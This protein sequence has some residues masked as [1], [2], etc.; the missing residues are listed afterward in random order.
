[1]SS[2]L[3]LLRDNVLREEFFQTLQER[4]LTQCEKSSHSLPERVRI[5][6]KKKFSLIAEKFSLLLRSCFHIL[7]HYE[8]A[9]NRYKTEF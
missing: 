8:T 1:M 5:H 3:T 9:L 7:T 6:C 2:V 4:A